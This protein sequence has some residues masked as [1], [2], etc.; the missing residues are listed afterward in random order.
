MYHIFIYFS[1]DG[2]LDCFHVLAIVN[3]AAMNV[4]VHVYFQI[5]VFC[6][7]RPRSGIA[8]S[9]DSSTFSIWRNLHTFS[10]VAVPIYI[11]TNI[12]GG[13]LFSTCFPAF[14]IC[15]FF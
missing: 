4:G 11:P 3:S 1:V 12:A 8:G 6:G 10:M 9:Y 2:H 5:R 14:I 15:R 7:Y 13:F